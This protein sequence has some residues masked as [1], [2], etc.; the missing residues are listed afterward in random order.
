MLLKFKCKIG[1]DVKI[2]LVRREA[3]NCVVPFGDCTHV[4][5]HNI[6]MPLVALVPFEKMEGFLGSAF[7]EGV[8]GL[9]ADT[10]SAQTAN[11]HER[12]I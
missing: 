12:M 3:I 5:V 2:A 7:A 4:Y 9:G 11:K 1:E 6:A 8:L 10:L